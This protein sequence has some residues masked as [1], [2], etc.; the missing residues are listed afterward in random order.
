MTRR[1][2]A[3]ELQPGDLVFGGSPVHHVGLYIGGGM[4]IH[5][6]R[7]GDVIRIASIYS[8][9]KPVSFGRL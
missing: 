8:T 4:M 6:P 2:T 1:I 9:S 5:A 3:D 7:T